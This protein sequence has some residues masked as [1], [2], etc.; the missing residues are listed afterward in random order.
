MSEKYFVAPNSPYSNEALYRIVCYIGKKYGGSR[1]KKVYIKKNKDLIDGLELI[2]ATYNNMRFSSVEL[3]IFELI[4]DRR[5]TKISKSQIRR[6]IYNSKFEI[7]RLPVNTARILITLKIIVDRNEET[8]KMC[9]EIIRKKVVALVKLD[10]CV[11]RL[12]NKT[13]SA[14]QIAKDFI[15]FDPENSQKADIIKEE[16][17][18]LL[19]LTCDYNALEIMI[20]NKRLKKEKK[21]EAISQYKIRAE[22]RKSTEE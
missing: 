4:G 12:L 17:E 11:R 3:K 13:Y 9:K 16:I 8:M 22:E 6:I 21:E 18:E 10:P 15:E 14:F 7:M 20:E 5:D 19:D 2:T 1:R